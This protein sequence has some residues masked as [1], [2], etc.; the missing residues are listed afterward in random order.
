MEADQ[1][2]YSKNINGEWIYVLIYVDDV[3]VASRNLQ[4]IEKV[5]SMLKSEFSTNCL[6]DVKLYLEIQVSR[7]NN[8]G[9]FYIHQGIYIRKFWRYFN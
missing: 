4:L 9:V 2:L 5:E 3:L 8:D 1:C 6:G 7:D